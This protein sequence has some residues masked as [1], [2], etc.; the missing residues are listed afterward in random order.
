[1]TADH[2]TPTAPL[3]AQRKLQ[4]RPGLRL[5][6]D[7][8]A[9]QGKTQRDA[10]AAA[11]MNETALSRALQKPHVQLYLENLKA[12]DA[13]DA[14]ALKRRATAMAIRR[15]VELMHEAKSEAVQARM[16]ELFAGEHLR[17]ASG[18]TSVT[19]NVGSGGYAY[20]P[21]GTRIVEVIPPETD[22]ASGGAG[23]IIEHDQGDST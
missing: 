4:L 12:Q 22:T 11:G 21:P 23:E 10:A 1:M 3:P 6:L 8:I 7:L 9:F 19:V 15:G 14:L 17:G 20:T 16:V 18:G 5:A 2:H 13:I